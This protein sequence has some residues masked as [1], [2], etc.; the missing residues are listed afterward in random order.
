MEQNKIVI[1]EDSSVAYLHT[2]GTAVFMKSRSS[3]TPP[4]KAP[5]APAVKHTEPVAFNINI[6]DVA[7]WGDDNQF[8][9]NVIA[10]ADLS[11]LIGSTIGW[12]VSAL[13]GGGFQYGKLKYDDNGNETFIPVNN[14][15]VVN[16]WMRMTNINRYL[17]ESL[18]NYYHFYN[19]FPKLTK[20]RDGK[21]IAM[22][23]NVDASFC[24]WQKQN[25]TNGLIENCFVSARWALGGYFGDRQTIPVIDPYYD[26]VYNIKNRSELQFI[27][28]LSY[29]TPG[30]T[31]YSIAPWNTFRTSKWFDVL[32]SIPIFKESIMDNQATIK[33]HVE[34]AEWWWKM[35]YPEWDSLASTPDVRRALMKKELENFEAIMTGAQNAGK[36]LMSSM[37]L[38][39][40]LGKEYSGWKITEL[41]S[42]I[43]SGTYIEDSREAS[44]HALYAFEVD[45][46]LIGST[47][48]NGLGAG[49]GS[50]KRVAWNL[51][52]NKMQIHE[53]LIM[54]PLYFIRDYNG[55]DADYVFRFKKQQ[56][57]TLNTGSE[58]EPIQSIAPKQQQ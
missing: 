57:V 7:I 19:A 23:Q 30:K 3:G 33:Y 32:K 14:D 50:D 36:I 10:D 46:T 40:I 6:N 29:P 11:T 31:Y 55:W 17:R 18:T 56:V 21:T 38:D 16:Q 28:P 34:V 54:E 58:T 20:S 9:Q 12:K 45:G 41:G 5:D 25:Q 52:V 24:R 22:I 1:S 26:P 53:D 8:P 43:Q 2:S 51:Y 42:K 13:Y 47:P 35:K 15:K 37:K 39:T 48:G 4:P 49:S 44:S 27:Y